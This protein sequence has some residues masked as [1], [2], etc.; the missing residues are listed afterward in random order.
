[1]GLSWCESC[2]VLEGETA[3]E[4]NGRVVC[5]YCQEEITYLPEHD[6]YADR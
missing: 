5:A 1:M 3:E 6:D 4:T 2:C